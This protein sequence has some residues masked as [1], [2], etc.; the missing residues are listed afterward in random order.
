MGFHVS[1][2]EGSLCIVPIETKIKGELI[3][4]FEDMCSLLGSKLVT[5]PNYKGT[6]VCTV[7][8]AVI[9]P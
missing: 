1:L 8:G 6:P 2:G 7:K 9:R 3:C 5:M 4:S